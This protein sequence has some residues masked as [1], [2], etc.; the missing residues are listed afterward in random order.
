MTSPAADNLTT[1]AQAS[2]ASTGSG[3]HGRAS[4]PAPRALFIV[5]RGA[6]LGAQHAVRR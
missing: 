4:V 5:A 6:R 1:A 3:F 2:V